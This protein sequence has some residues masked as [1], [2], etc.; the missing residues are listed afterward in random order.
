MVRQEI[1][2]I[3][4]I[5]VTDDKKNSVFDGDEFITRTASKQRVEEY[6]S[7][8][9]NLEQT[10]EKSKLP[11]W[12]QIVEGLCSVFFL[13]VLVATA[14]AG[15]NTAMKNAPYLVI[16]GAL[17]GVIWLILFLVSKVREKKVLK[18]ECADQKAG[19]VFEDYKSLQ[20]ELDVPGN[21]AEMDVLVFRYKLKN[22]K[23]RPHASALQSTAYMNVSVRIF[24]DSDTVH[25]AELENVYSFKKSEISAITVVKKR[26]SVSNWTKDEDPRKGRFK[27]YKMTVMNTGDVSF[28]PYYILEIIHEGQLFGLYFPCYELE[29]VEK[30]TGLKAD[31]AKQ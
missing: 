16:S 15:F 19:A 13:L 8:R 21:A 27:P 6:E 30:I 12:L 18:E 24:A 17:C 11:L 9:E 25:I 14:K 23:L 3:F 5:D 1:K 4:G 20:S 10:L 7:K 28:K 31:I 26:I 29:T 22:G 2:P